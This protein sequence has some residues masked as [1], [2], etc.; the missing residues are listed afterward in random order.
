MFKTNHNLKNFLR[1]EVLKNKNNIRDALMIDVPEDMGNE[2]SS[3]SVQFIETSDYESSVSKF[4]LPNNS[5]GNIIISDTIHTLTDPAI[6]LI[7]CVNILKPG[8][9]IRLIFQ[10]VS[11]RNLL[12][13]TIRGD[14]LYKSVFNGRNYV[15][16]FTKLS[17]F[18]WIKKINDSLGSSKLEVISV[19]SFQ[20]ITSGDSF[21]DVCPVS[22]DEYYFVHLK[23]QGLCQN[24]YSLILDRLAINE[25]R[26]NRLED[27]FSELIAREQD[28]KDNILAISKSNESVKE[29]IVELYNSSVTSF[30]KLKVHLSSVNNFEELK[31]V[32]KKFKEEQKG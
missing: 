21:F 12:E 6:V 9:N 3:G 5:F 27:Y 23:K 25:D 1:E 16:F 8:G 29:K 20:S 17:F 19:D 26:I 11:S 22:D 30:E 10:D 24:L 4:N 18:E 31:G 28:L 2:M 32:V 7:D 13:R 14:M 15:R